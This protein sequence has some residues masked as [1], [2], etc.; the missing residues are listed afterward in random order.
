MP[1]TSVSPSWLYLRIKASSDGRCQ[2]QLRSRLFLQSPSQTS[3]LY[4]PRLCLAVLS[5]A[6]QNKHELNTFASACNMSHMPG[7]PR[8]ACYYPMP[9]D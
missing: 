4:P 7:T 5:E 3:P 1:M 2:T 8:P 9:S 6:A